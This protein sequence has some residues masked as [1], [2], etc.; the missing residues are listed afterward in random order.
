[1]GVVESRIIA[2]NLLSACMKAEE[3]GNDKLDEQQ[4]WND[5]V[6]FSS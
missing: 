6:R 4:F 1:M 2:Q 5:K 3:E